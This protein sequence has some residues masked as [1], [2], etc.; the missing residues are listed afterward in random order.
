MRRPEQI[1]WQ[2]LRPQLVKAGAL[3]QRHEDRL[4]VGIPD[5]S[6]VLDGRSGWIELKAAATVTS[7]LKLR[8][9]QHLWM[10]ARTNAGCPCMILAQVGCGLWYGGLVGHGFIQ[11]SDLWVPTSCA[12]LVALGGMS[13]SDPVVLIWAL[14]DKVYR[15]SAHVDALNRQM[16]K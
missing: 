3:V 7:A 6:I 1:V 2:R 15:S 12:R 10:A 5:I 14:M 16:F 11:P 9:Q 8:D 13:H 4:S